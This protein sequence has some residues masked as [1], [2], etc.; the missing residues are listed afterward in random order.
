V[1]GKERRNLR[2]KKS[3]GENLAFLA[4]KYE[5]DPEDLLYA[6][7]LAKETKESRC[8]KLSIQCRGKTKNKFIFLIRIESE[9]IAQFPIDEEFL[10]NRSN[11]L[12][13]FMDTPE[14]RSFLARRARTA[15]ANSIKDLR[16]GMRHVNL[17]AKILEVEEPKYLATRYGNHASLAKAT[18]ADETGTIKLCL[19]NGQIATASVGDIVQIKNAR[20]SAFRGESQ[21]SLGKTGVVSSVE[22]FEPQLT[23][24]DLPTPTI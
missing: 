19:W 1:K 22:I 12:R 15:T 7:R 5:V 4:V 23:M 3:I 6:V 9:I 24:I 8:G 16:I 18:I 14:I 13:N 20:V 21:L 10:L 2:K 17:T 11:H